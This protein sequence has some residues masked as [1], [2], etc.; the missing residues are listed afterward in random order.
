MLETLASVVQINKDRM[1]ASTWGHLAPM[2]NTTYRGEALIAITVFGGSGAT[3]VDFEFDKDLES[4]P[5]LFESLGD[6]LFDNHKEFEDGKVYKLSLTMRNYRWWAKVI[7]EKD[8][9]S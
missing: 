3:I 7:D 1:Y 6:F 8:L 2:K 5:W 9:N 4:S